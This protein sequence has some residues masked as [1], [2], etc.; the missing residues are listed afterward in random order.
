ME[1]IVGNVAGGGS[2]TDSPGR[3]AV[4]STEVGTTK[5]LTER[6]MMITSRPDGRLTVSKVR[7]RR[8]ASG[9]AILA[10]EA[11]AFVAAAP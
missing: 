10:V 7:T 6:M 11:A 8:A 1:I 9:S 4:H 2:T 3:A 5:I